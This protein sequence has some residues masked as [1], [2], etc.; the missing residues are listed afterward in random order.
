MVHTEK[1][2]GMRGESFAL[3][4]KC[5]AGQRLS[6]A[7]YTQGLESEPRHTQAEGCRAVLSG[8]CY[9]ARL[10]PSKSTSSTLLAARCSFT[11]CSSSEP[12]ALYRRSS[13]LPSEAMVAELSW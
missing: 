13:M 3:P 10:V 2:C 4:L 5:A 12:L 9:V 6:V 7:D 11:V 1:W 8:A